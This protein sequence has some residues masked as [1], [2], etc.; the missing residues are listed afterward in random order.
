[1]ACPQC[2]GGLSI[3]A[4][5]A[6]TISCRYCSS[7]VFIPDA[8]W[9]RLHPVKLASDWS[10]S[11]RDRLLSAEAL[12][13]RASQEHAEAKRQAQ[14]DEQQARRRAQAVREQEQ[15]ALDARDEEARIARRQKT[16]LLVM[17]GVGVLT[18]GIAVWL[19]YLR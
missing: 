17:A 15:Q 7:A 16:L 14:Q 18:L 9:H 3:A 4:D 5:D 10:I 2:A 8:L 12:R 11:F 19:G 13:E 1:M 6:R